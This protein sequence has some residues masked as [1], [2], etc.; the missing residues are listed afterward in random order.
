MRDAGTVRLRRNDPVGRRGIRGEAPMS[1][2]GETGRGGSGQWSVVS[3]QWS[4]PAGLNGA[5]RSPAV[6]RSPFV[7]SVIR[8]STPS[9]CLRASVVSVCGRAKVERWGKAVE[10]YSSP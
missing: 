3:G 7:L 2:D 4:R 8:G 9:L 5:R 1:A 10:D 6:S